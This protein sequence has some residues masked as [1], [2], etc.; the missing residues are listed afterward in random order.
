MCSETLTVFITLASKDC[1]KG[2]IMF[3]KIPEGKEDSLCI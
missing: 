2:L 3:I 1:I